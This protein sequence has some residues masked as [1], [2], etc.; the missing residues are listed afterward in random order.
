MK[1]RT[2]LPHNPENGF[3]KSQDEIATQI[4]SMAANRAS[5]VHETGLTA[6]ERQKGKMTAEDLKRTAGRVPHMIE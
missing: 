1:I 3:G 5:R 6:R 4:K 2:M